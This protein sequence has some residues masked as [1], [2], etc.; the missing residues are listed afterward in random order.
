[1]SPGR[2]IAK[3]TA[4]MKFCKPL[5][6]ASLMLI[7]GN[8]LFNSNAQ[9]VIT[10][11]V[12]AVNPGYTDG[13]YYGLSRGGYDAEPYWGIVSLQVK[14]GSIASVAFVIRDSSLHELFDS[15]YEKHFRGNPLYIQ[16]CRNDLKGVSAYPQLLSQK[17][18]TSQLDA[19]SGAT[20]SYH[21][22]RG[23]VGNALR[24]SVSVTDTL[25]GSQ[26]QK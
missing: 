20:W 23:A 25:P 11:T 19:I 8:C 13:I 17:Q 16:Q 14:E 21:I 3:S 1:M 2:S 10:D 4:P 26:V 24:N 12:P 15:S 5:V 7:A 9:G 22:F 18:D 6:L